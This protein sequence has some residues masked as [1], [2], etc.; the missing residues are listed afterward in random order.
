MLGNKCRNCNN[1]CIILG[2]LYVPSGLTRRSERS[3]CWPT[4]KQWGDACS[5]SLDVWTRRVVGHSKSIHKYITSRRQ[6]IT[7]VGLRNLCITGLVAPSVKIR[8]SADARARA[9]WLSLA[10]LLSSR[11]TVRYSVRAFTLSSALLADGAN[12]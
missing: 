6:P 3:A 9:R 12:W 10:R 1:N 7:H 4:A 8:S 5:N 2:P 11:G